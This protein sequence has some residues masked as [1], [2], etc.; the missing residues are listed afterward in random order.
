MEE[1]GIK[2]SYRAPTL[3]HLHSGIYSLMTNHE[4]GVSAFDADAITEAT[5]NARREVHEIVN[6]LRQL[7]GVWKDLSVVATAEQIGVR[8]GRRIRGRYLLTADDLANGLRHEEAVCRANF[9]ID[10]HALDESGNKEVSQKFKA[11]GKKTVRYS[12]PI[13][14]RRGC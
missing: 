10:V 7:G 4:Y 2:P 5:I 13:V 14:S 8:E 9:P 1:N 3:R 6:G 12:V 11:K